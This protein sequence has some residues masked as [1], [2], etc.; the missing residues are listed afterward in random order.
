MKRCRAVDDTKTNSRCIGTLD[1]PGVHRTWK[2]GPGEDT[3]VTWNSPPDSAPLPE[4]WTYTLTRLESCP[5]HNYDTECIA[6]FDTLREAQDEA[7]VDFETSYGGDVT[8]GLD[9]HRHPVDERGLTTTDLEANGDV[10]R[11]R[12]YVKRAGND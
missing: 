12:I 8:G 11:Y 5:I 1:H 7:I 9:W 10:V 2:F 4:L 6:E 3:L